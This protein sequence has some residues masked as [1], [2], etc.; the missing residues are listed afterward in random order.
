MM[1]WRGETMTSVLS[2]KGL[3][4]LAREFGF[5]AQV[6]IAF[7][8]LFAL[9][10]CFWPSEANPRI[11]SDEAMTTALLAMTACVL[12]FLIRANESQE[13]RA[14]ASQG[15]AYADRQAWAAHRRAIEEGRP[16]FDHLVK[17]YCDL[18]NRAMQM[19]Y[20]IEIP[21][22]TSEFIEIRAYEVD[23]RTAAEHF[24]SIVV[25]DKG[26]HRKESGAPLP[27]SRMRWGQER[28]QG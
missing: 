15:W 3:V 8:C 22:T 19:G 2:R 7:V 5:G 10:V 26:G 25:V 1:K 18:V 4:D 6:Q 9:W 28:K 23:Q 24:F 17:E 14:N 16:E 27:A 12:A 13:A 20:E 11:P 21:R